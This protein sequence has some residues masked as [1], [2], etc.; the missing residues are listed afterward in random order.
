ME[1]M[2][3]DTVRRSQLDS[4]ITKAQEAAA[5]AAEVSPTIDM[6][7][8]LKELNNSKGDFN[9]LFPQAAD[10]ADVTLAIQWLQKTAKTAAESGK[11]LQADAYGATRSLGGTS[12]QGL[13]ARELAS[14]AD[15]ITKDPRAMAD[16]VFNPDT[17][18]KMA[19]AQRKGKLSKAADLATMLG[20]SAAKFAP[21]VGPMADTTQPEDI[22]QQAPS[23]T[24]QAQA[25]TVDQQAAIE[26]LKKRGLWNE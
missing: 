24:G 1:S 21:R 5:G 19:E 20:T 15:M 22:T 7:T 8:L 25:T 2:V 13:I 26:E 4:V 9:Y 14:L 12:Q 3:L 18:K 23:M 10:K 16:V 6:K 11:S 17:L